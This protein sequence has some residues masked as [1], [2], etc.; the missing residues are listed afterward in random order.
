LQWEGSLTL[1]EIL[2]RHPKGKEYAFI[3]EHEP[4]HPLLTD[5]GGA[6]LSYPPIINSADLGAVQVGDSELFIELTGT[7]LQAVTLSA[8]IAACDLADQGYEIEPVEIR[9]AFDTA[10]GKLY[11]TPFYFQ[12]S[13]FC[14]LARVHRFLGEPVSAKECVAALERI[15]CGAE[16]THGQ[17]RGA[18]HAE[19]GAAEQEGILARIAEYR[20][21]YLHAADIVEDIMIGRGLAAFTPQKPADFTIGRLSPLTTLSRAVKA[22]LTGMGYQE[23]IY[24]YLTSRAELIDNMRTDGSRAIQIANPMSEKYE[25]VRDSILPNLM[26]SESVSANAAY[27]HLLY[28]IGKIAYKDPSR[29]SG[30]AT[31]QYTGILHAAPDANYNVIACQIQTLFYYLNRAYTVRETAD[32]RFITGRAAAL[33]YK[34]HPI[35]IFGEV[36]PEVLANFNIT[37]PC[38]ACEFDI[39]MLL[40]HPRH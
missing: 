39:D 36:H 24:N 34:D 3:L 37:T 30:A 12:E 32:P 25:Y 19:T 33:I 11:T 10:F 4:L 38:T 18:P 6:I 16:K 1:R 14:S 9:S 13:V 15:G 31:R 27:P 28:E 22:T 7:D 40:E 26:T 35:G 20:N 2:A 23:M 8:S 21:D 17:E 29:N 5:A